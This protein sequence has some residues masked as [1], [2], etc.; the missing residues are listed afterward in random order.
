MIFRTD[1][2]MK[3]LNISKE[4]REKGLIRLKRGLYSDSPVIDIECLSSFL[5]GPSY[6]SFEYAC[7]LYG[8]IPESVFALTCAVANKNR[9]KYIEVGYLNMWFRY[10]DVP[11]KVFSLGLE[12]ITRKDGS[13]LLASPEKALCDNLYQHKGQRTVKDV[14]LLLFEDL[15]I[16]EDLFETLDKK[17]LVDLASKYPSSTMHN[18]VKFIEDRYAIDR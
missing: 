9:T 6:I 4:I 2:H 17:K 16:D 14:E 8:L 11:E 12:K 7:S 13:F 15:R 1:K 18:F 5:Y 10:K 3:E